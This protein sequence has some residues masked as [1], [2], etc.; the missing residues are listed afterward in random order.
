MPKNTDILL[1]DDDTSFCESVKRYFADR[2]LALLSVSDP[3]LA[4]ALN[5]CHFRVIL[6]DIDMP[7]ITGQDLLRDIRKSEKPIV[8]M[9]SGHSDE[10]IRLGCLNQG[11]DFFFSKPV[12]L[13]ELSLVVQRALGR[14]YVVH[15]QRSWTIIKSES[16]VALPNGSIVG[17]SSA[18]YRVLEQLILN[19]PNPVSREILTQVVTGDVD[20][21]S[22]FTRG[23]E[24]MISRL[25]GRLSN[26]DFRLPV[27]A[28]RNVG[29]VFHGNGTL[30][31]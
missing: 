31:D 24:V 12:H 13:E 7:E 16:A 21:T 11:A 30:I 23:L 15:D 1:I 22:N 10:H 5:F 9:V 3:R 14:T 4:K 18:E 25:R 17:L 26:K 28:L 27:R 2:D 8:I 19:A 29:Y 20:Q 6:L